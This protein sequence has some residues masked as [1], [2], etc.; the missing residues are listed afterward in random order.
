MVRLLHKGITASQLKALALALMLLDH[1]HYFFAFTGLVP[2]WFTQAGRLA[3]PLFLFC[4]VEGFAHTRDRRRYFLRIYLLGAAMGGLE[5]FMMYGG[6]LNQA[7]GFFP[8]N[9]ILQ[10]LTLCILLWQGIDWLRAGRFLPGAAVILG[11]ALWPF[12][13]AQLST[14]PGLATPVGLVCF[15]L[16]PAWPLITDGG[17]YFILGGVLLHLFRGTRWQLPLWA[18]WV[19]LTEFLLTGYL[20][21]AAEQWGL[22]FTE[23]YQWFALLAALPMALYN[24]RR[25]NGP[26]WLYYWFYPAHIYLL[27]GLS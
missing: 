21:G 1:I 25:G 6:F 13:A 23:Y 11:V 18:A 27:Y 3:A 15:T 4:A 20:V 16:L 8:Q 2:L 24:G 17:V 9:A 12:A 19:F 10:S 22:L 5:F 7:D 14:L 26:K